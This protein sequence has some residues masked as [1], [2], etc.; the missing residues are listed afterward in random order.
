[1][2]TIIDLTRTISHQMP[3]H[4]GDLPVTFKQVAFMQ[5]HAFSDFQLTT[6]MHVGTHI[7]GPRHMITGAKTIAQIS[8]ENFIGRGVL[9]DARKQE[10]T[11]L[12][13]QQQKIQ[14]GDIVLVMTGWDVYWNSEQYFTQHPFVDIAFAQE[15]V[16]KQIKMVGFDMSGPDKP[17]YTIHK[18]FFQHNIMVIENLMNLNELVGVS[19]FEVYALPLKID[20]DSALAR[21][22]AVF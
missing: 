9:I 2:K 7:D 14:K 11:S 12:L 17:P 5:E 3:V 16:V 18:M 15:L 8:P 22:I 13:L 6:G 1:M 10:I 21:V 20:S 19:S 4:P